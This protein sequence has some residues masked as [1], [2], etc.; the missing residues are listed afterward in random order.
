[1]CNL[2][3]EELKRLI[4]QSVWQSVRGGDVHI[5]RSIATFFQS[6]FSFTTMSL[7]VLTSLM[8]TYSNSMVLTNLIIDC[9]VSNLQVGLQVNTWKGMVCTT[10]LHGMCHNKIPIALH[11]LYFDSQLC[12]CVGKETKVSLKRKY[13][14]WSSHEVEMLYGLIFE[15][16]LLTGA[17][18]A[19]MYVSKYSTM[20]TVEAVKLKLYTLRKS[21][22]RVVH[23]KT[24]TD[25]YLNAITDTPKF[26]CSLS[27][28]LLF[29]KNMQKQGCSNNSIE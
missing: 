14:M 10:S 7:S 17:A 6:S 15:N 21:N 26:T 11:I 27:C 3:E 29:Q 25:V 2:S 20:H 13:N 16:P 9:F 12:F 22:P 23:A 4:I 1:M 28:R 8:E 18:I 24:A 5:L 19:R